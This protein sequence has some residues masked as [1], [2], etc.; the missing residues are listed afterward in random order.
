VRKLLIIA[1]FVVALEGHALAASPAAARSQLESL[2]WREAALSQQMGADRHALARLLSALELFSRDPPPPLLVSPSDAKGAVRA[3]IL[4]RAIAPALE[5]RAQALARQAKALAEV[6]RQAAVASGD[7]FAAES[8]IADRQGRLD[9]IAHDAALLN[10]PGAGRPVAR[11]GMAQSP[12][13]RLE[14]P[15]QGVVAVRFGGKLEGGLRSRGLAYR[16]SPGAV[17]RSPAAAQVVFAGPLSGW[18]QIVILRGA[19]GRHILL[20]GLGKVTVAPG[21]SVAA[22]FPLGTMPTGGHLAPELYLEV[23]LAGEPVDPAVMMNGP[24]LFGKPRSGGE[25]LTRSV[26]SGGR[27]GAD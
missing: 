12:P 10:L 11:G 7:L 20:S 24:G 15:T 3:M 5:S 26:K 8:A 16:V 17:V 14:P 13:A 2:Y 9:A 21:Q 25:F 27:E 19:G 6:R 18:G 23:R 22:T 1:G 4:A